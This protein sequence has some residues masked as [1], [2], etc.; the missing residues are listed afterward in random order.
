ME[1]ML[2]NLIKENMQGKPISEAILI[3]KLDEEYGELEKYF[4]FAQNVNRMDVINNIRNRLVSGKNKKFTIMTAE[5]RR[6]MKLRE[7]FIHKRLESAKNAGVDILQDKFPNVGPEQI[8][9]DLAEDKLKRINYMANVAAW[10]QFCSNR[11]MCTAYYC[12]SRD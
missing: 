9:A 12:S 11:E 10:C 7:L 4:P 8:E 3:Q 1:V 2:E 5:D 6:Y